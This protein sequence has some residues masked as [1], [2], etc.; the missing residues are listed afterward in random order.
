MK[1]LLERSELLERS[2]LAAQ[3]ELSAQSAPKKRLPLGSAL[4]GAFVSSMIIVSAAILSTVVLTSCG[5][6]GAG[7]GGSSGQMQPLQP[8]QP[9]QKPPAS[10]LP[11]AHPIEGGV[12]PRTPL[13][14][15]Q[16]FTLG[17]LEYTFLQSRDKDHVGLESN[18]AMRPQEGNKYFLVRYLV[19]N[20]GASSVTVPNTAAVKLLNL[21]TNLFIDLDQAATNA[22]IMSGAAT[23]LPDQLTLDPGQPNIQTLVFQL[24]NIDQSQ[25]SLVVF[26]PANP[27]VFQAVKLSN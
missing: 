14:F 24:P 18:P 13:P 22:N 7:G 19:T 2:A 1:H 16:S 3:S 17:S 10:S 6:G 21:S 11:D 5:G 9:P 15:N 8:G 20:R 25:L 27:Q 4:G 26:D 12:T 23:G